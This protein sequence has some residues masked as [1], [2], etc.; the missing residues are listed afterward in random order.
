L[1]ARPQYR[2]NRPG[3]NHS[4]P[5]YVLYAPSPTPISCAMTYMVVELITCV[6]K[7]RLKLMER[8]SDEIT[9]YLSKYPMSHYDYPKPSPT[10]SRRP[11]HVDTPIIKQ[12]MIHGPCADWAKLL[13]TIDNPIDLKNVSVEW[14]QVRKRERERERERGREREGEKT[15]V[16]WRC[17]FNNNQSCCEV[18]TVDD[19]SIGRDLLS[20]IR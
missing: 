9:K 4:R 8:T 2:E 17:H 18:T 13:I 5:V 11:H 16:V 10:P 1:G 3:Q 6:N 20:G 12:Q 14:K 7:P 19:S 15:I